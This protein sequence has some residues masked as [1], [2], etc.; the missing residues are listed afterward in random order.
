LNGN[1]ALGGLTGYSYAYEPFAAGGLGEVVLYRVNPGVSIT[2]I[3]SQQVTL[4]PSKDYR[5]IL[6]VYG[7]DLHGQVWEIGG[8][9]VAE[10]FATDSMYA[11]GFSGLL[12]YS[13]SPV[14]PTDFTADNFVTQ[15]PEPT[16]GALAGLGALAIAALRRMRRQS[17]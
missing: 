16:A 5:F 11:S 13:Q 9:L 4:D 7:S 14:P 10:R 2:D 3:G 12:G 17:R 15:V 1:N 6:E 8:G